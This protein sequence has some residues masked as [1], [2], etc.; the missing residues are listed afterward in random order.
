MSLLALYLSVPEWIVAVLVT[1]GFICLFFEMSFPSENVPEFNE[2]AGTDF[3][4]EQ[5]R[6]ALAANDVTRQTL[7]ETLLG[8]SLT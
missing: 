7:S 4:V 6:K 2:P 8:Q 3:Y 5:Q 1:L